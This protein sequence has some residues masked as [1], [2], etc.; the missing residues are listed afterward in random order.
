MPPVSHKISGSIERIDE[1]RQELVVTNVSARVVLMW[2]K[3][4]S[5]DLTCL[6]AGDRI[7]AGR[8]V[9][10]DFQFPNEV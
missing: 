10:R 1:E 5:L 4:D 7:K 2:R 8:L 9:I 6:Q 3:T